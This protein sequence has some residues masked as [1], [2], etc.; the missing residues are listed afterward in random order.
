[1]E[2]PPT[3]AAGHVRCQHSR[4]AS[5]WAG[6]Q[7]RRRRRA[8]VNAWAVSGRRRTLRGQR[9]PTVG[10]LRAAR[11][12]AVARRQGASSSWA[13]SPG[14]VP[15]DAPAAASIV[16]R[17]ASSVLVFGMPLPTPVMIPDPAA[18]LVA[19]GNPWSA[20]SSWRPARRHLRDGSRNR[21]HRRKHAGTPEGQ[22]EGAPRG[23]PLKEAEA[24]ARRG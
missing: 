21:G 11:A 22:D 3:R 4:S 7:G 8:G 17:S 9:R 2:R 16:R 10:R 19:P 1:M 18:I 6:G 5:V 20:G 23:G 15:A 14:G 13:R 12:S 24:S